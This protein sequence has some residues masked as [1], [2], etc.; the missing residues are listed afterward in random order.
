MNDMRVS[1]EITDAREAPAGAAT[2]VMVE[3]P[4][5]AMQARRS[6]LIKMFACVGEGM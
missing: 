6:A 2:P 1:F 3:R 5:S 4:K